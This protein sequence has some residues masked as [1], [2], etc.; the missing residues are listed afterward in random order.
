MKESAEERLDSALLTPPCTLEELR[1][2][3]RYRR[4]PEEFYDVVQPVPLQGAYV[5]SVSHSAAELIELSPGQL[6]RD[7]LVDYLNGHKTLPNA[8]PIAMCYSGHQFGSRV[9]RLG[10]GRA[11]VLGQ[12][13]NSQGQLW[14]LQLKGSGPT[15]YSRGGDGRA[16]L[17]SSIRE[18]LCSE[19]MHAL[20][21]PT[22]R[23]LCLIGSS[24]PV[25]R[26]RVEPG[27]MILR[28]AQSLVRFGSFEYF[29]YTQKFEY[30]KLLADYVV[31]EFY[32]HLKEKE[33]PYLALFISVLERTAKLI[34]QWQ[35]VGF[36]HGVMNSDNMSIL[37]LTL[38]Y[39]PF[40]FL[41]TYESEFICNHSDHTGHYAFDK[42]PYNGVFNLSCL[43]QGLLPLLHEDK[44]ESLELAQ[45][46]LN[47]YWK[48]YRQA[49]INVIRAKLGLV[50]QQKEDKE[51]WDDL[52]GLME[53]QVDFTNFF[54]ALCN[55]N[56]QQPSDNHK[57]RDMF[58]NREAFDMWAQ[59]YANRLG[60]EASNDDKRCQAMKKVN[61]KYILRNYLA[62]AAIR[63]A[64]DESDY[65][66]VEK[67]KQ[68]LQ[69]PF[70]EQ[71]EN[72]SYA[73]LPP[74]W[75]QSISVS[76]SS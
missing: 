28:M 39:G 71:P 6:Q 37:G 26:E 51:L 10:D 22:T 20:N 16:V 29:Y 36:S 59:R 8:E 72:E 46:H 57:L 68:L 42:Q 19:A 3:N 12:V 41:D 70:D 48:I 11:I 64:E 33:N 17:R 18:Y 40:G 69:R 23:A 14:D 5:A 32:P 63:K 4:F 52:L 43:A 49:E 74:E 67:L 2:D 38:D 76:C 65:S 56:R 27:A 50:E 35:G 47:G 44:N 7:D 75:A 73:A 61:P 53:G 55:F 30:I 54:R 31:D 45:H 1:F 58:L 66:E 25:Y 60:S 34:A 15:L 62:E 13:R 24:E 9:P 21:I